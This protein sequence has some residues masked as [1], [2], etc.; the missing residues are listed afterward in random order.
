L[1]KYHDCICS[2]YSSCCCN[3]TCNHPPLN[4]FDLPFLIANLHQGAITRMKWSVIQSPR[5]PKDSYKKKNSS[6]LQDVPIC[7]ELLET[8][9]SALRFWNPKQLLM[10]PRYSHPQVFVAATC[11]QK[12]I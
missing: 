8:P 11:T 9:W 6:H 7:D 5:Q 4:K 10:C 2:W 3:F 12:T 1:S